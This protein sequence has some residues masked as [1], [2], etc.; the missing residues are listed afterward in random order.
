MVDPAIEPLDELI[1]RLGARITGEENRRIVEH[2]TR[3]AAAIAASALANPE[4]VEIESRILA[5]QLA[6]ISASEV[7][8]LRHE[9]TSWLQQLVQVV[10]AGAFAG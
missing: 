5:A 10:I 9:I 1:E 4:H 3:D 2:I 8:I 6:N 7:Q